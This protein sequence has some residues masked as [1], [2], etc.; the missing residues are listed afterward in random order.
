MKK[1]LLFLATCTLMLS[2]NSCD[3]IADKL[4][5]SFDDVVIEETLDISNLT[6]KSTSIEGGEESYIF[7]DSTTFN[8]SQ[9]SSGNNADQILHEYLGSLSLVKVKTITFLIVDNI[10]V[11]QSL[12]VNNL[13][14]SILK[15]DAELYSETFTDITPGGS[16]DASSIDEQVLGAISASLV[17][18]EDLTFKAS[19]E[20]T[21]DVQNFE[22]L[23]T[24]ISDIEANAI[25]A[26]KSN[27]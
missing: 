22:I 18:N 2:L 16:I 23:A 25:D 4:S 21:G 14:I 11:D 27:L 10:P 7:N 3:E 12:I 6:P 9:A 5:I 17:D 24:I 8:L 20:V 26:V 13:V 19:G 15:G 1:S